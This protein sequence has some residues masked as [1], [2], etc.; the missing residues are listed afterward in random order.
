MQQQSKK[1]VDPFETPV[2]P[3]AFKIEKSADSVISSDDFENSKQGL[4]SKQI[5]KD[6]TKDS[7]FETRLTKKKADLFTQQETAE[8]DTKIE[9]LT[10][11]AKLVEYKSVTNPSKIKQRYNKNS[12]FEEDDDEDDSVL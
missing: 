4:F 6:A 12:L 8:D 3:Y 11:V 1:R 2:N 7:L 10:D 5:L 9:D